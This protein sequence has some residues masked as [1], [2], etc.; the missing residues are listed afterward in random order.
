[1]HDYNINF[2]YIQV[3]NIFLSNMY[4]ILLLVYYRLKLP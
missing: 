1:M 2:N 3:I 4:Y